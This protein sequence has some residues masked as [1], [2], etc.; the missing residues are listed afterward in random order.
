MDL[1]KLK[2]VCFFICNGCIALGM[3]L[4]LAT[5]WTDIADNEICYKA[6]LTIALVFISSA[7]TMSLVLVLEGKKKTGDN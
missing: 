3:L 4:G 5:I 7:L 1:K 6:W 2:T